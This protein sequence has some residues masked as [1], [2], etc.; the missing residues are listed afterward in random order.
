MRN[1]RSE[2]E[3]QHSCYVPTGDIYF[4]YVRYYI[5]KATDEIRS[6]KAFLIIQTV[7]QEDFLLYWSVAAVITELLPRP[8]GVSG[9]SEGQLLSGGERLPLCPP[10]RQHHDRHQRQHGDR[11]HGLHQGPVLPGKVQ[12]LPPARPPAGQNQGHP[13]PGE[14]G[15]SRRGHGEHSVRAR[16]H[17][18]VARTLIRLREQFFLS[19]LNSIS[20]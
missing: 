13:A 4:L 17:T 20:E 5:L 10:G 6:S 7:G 14:P 9:I 2:N 15:H 12:V 8:T 3:H 18:Q 16:S 11:V 1:I 19:A